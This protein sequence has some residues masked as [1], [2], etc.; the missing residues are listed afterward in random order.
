MVDEP[1]LHPHH[2]A[3]G[4]YREGQTVRLAGQRVVA[5][6]SGRTAAA[7]E[8]IWRDDAV[9]IGIEHAAR[10]NQPVPISGA[11]VLPRIAARGVAV[12][13][14]A[15]LDQD[16]VV[17]LTVEVAVHLVGRRHG[18]KRFSVFEHKR[19]SLR[20]KGEV[21]HFDQAWR[22]AIS[23]FQSALVHA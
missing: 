23:H 22:A 13:G 10:P 18:R 15:V 16:H 5:G 21:L 8:H 17:A 6:R 9:S 1:F 11:P 12:A 14:Q 20:P 19:L 2:I 7:A 4:H 3:Y